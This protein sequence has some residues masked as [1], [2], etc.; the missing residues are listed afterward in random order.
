MQFLLNAFAQCTTTLYGVEGALDAKILFRGYMQ[1]THVRVGTTCQLI[2]K[3][4][5]YHLLANSLFAPRS[6]AFLEK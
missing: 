5:P 2:I 3:G 6:H 4:V 1:Q